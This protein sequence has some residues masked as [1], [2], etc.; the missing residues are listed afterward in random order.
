MSTSC[1][2]PYTAELESRELK[3]FLQKV[4]PTDGYFGLRQLLAC[5]TGGIDSIPASVPSEALPSNKG[6]L[7]PIILCGHK[8]EPRLR[9]SIQQSARCDGL[10]GVQHC[11]RYIKTAVTRLRS[12]REIVERRPETSPVECWRRTPKGR[13]KM[14]S[15][16]KVPP[17]G[18]W[19]DTS[20][21]EKR[22][23][24]ENHDRPLM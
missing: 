18:Q 4:A 3:A 9:G 23:Y 1:N 2:R 16:R 14:S 17:V 21:Y 15:R 11:R 20:R 19:R 10:V 22:H 12:E 24:S 8:G 7:C 5:E 6:P 13:L